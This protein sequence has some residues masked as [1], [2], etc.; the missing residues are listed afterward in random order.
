[1][2]PYEIIQPGGSVEHWNEESGAT[3][4]ARLTNHWQRSAWLNPVPPAYWGGTHSVR[5]V[6]DILA[7]R[8]FPLTPAGLDAMIQSLSR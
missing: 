3:W 6:R 7:D 1:M 8:M 4:L 2:S 5:L